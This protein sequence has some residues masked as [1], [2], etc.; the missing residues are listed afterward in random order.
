MIIPQDMEK[1]Y[2]RF[3]SGRGS[4]VDYLTSLLG[5]DNG[6]CTRAGAWAALVISWIYFVQGKLDLSLSY[7]R[8]SL[9]IFY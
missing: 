6:A 8:R 1:R 2:R 7:L 4:V 5:K 9:R 3:L